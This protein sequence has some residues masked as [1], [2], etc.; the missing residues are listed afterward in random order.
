MKKTFPLWCPVVLIMALATWF[1][2]R[3]A[4]KHFKETRGLRQAR[5]FMAAGDYRNAS[6][7]A[8]QTLE[9]APNSL[10][11][12]SIMADLPEKVRSPN[13]PDCRPRLAEITPS[14]GNN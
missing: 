5:Q 14:A 4:Y 9:I 6:L 3:P 11:A 2:G 12:C 10:E 7:S 1:C 13:A 8:R